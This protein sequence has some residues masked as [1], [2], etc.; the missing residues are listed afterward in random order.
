MC[1]SCSVYLKGRDM[2]VRTVAV[3]VLCLVAFD[4]LGIAQTVPALKIV[5]VEGDGVI[6]D[7]RFSSSREPVIEVQDENNQ[8]VDGARVTFLLPE[9][10]AGG[11]FF[12]S[13]RSLSV[14]TNASGRAIG[15]GFRHN[16]TEG[17][18][19]ILVTAAQ[20]DRT[21]SIAI[22]QS[23]VQP[24]EGANL[25]APSRGFWRGKVVAGIAA[26]AIIGAVAA[27]RGGDDG[28]PS[29]T[30]PG[31]AITPGTVSVGTPR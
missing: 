18:F 9:R 1:K 17:A 3:L 24:G 2:K 30:N 20:G 10:G 8:P 15:I 29:T 22:S 12:G 23:N 21:G 28:G 11:T 4:G 14:T 26:A 31:T 7:I 19:Q 5:V 27:T 6:N 16:L 13:G 25:V